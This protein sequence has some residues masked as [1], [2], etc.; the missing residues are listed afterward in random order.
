MLCAK[1]TI[2]QHLVLRLIKSKLSGREIEVA[3][4]A[5]TARASESQADE[6]SARGA[7][8]GGESSVAAVWDG[9]GTEVLARCQGKRTGGAAG[10][11]VQR[12][13]T[14]K[15]GHSLVS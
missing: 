4:T 12:T 10:E 15:R 9:C 5:W 14:K 1:Q 7:G 13:T 11:R 8:A 2:G 6:A 3:Q